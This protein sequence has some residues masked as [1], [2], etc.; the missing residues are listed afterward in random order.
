MEI[1]KT[2]M[3]SMGLLLS[4]SIYA[5]TVLD[6]IVKV[7]P[8]KPPLLFTA[9]VLSETDEIQ[10]EFVGRDG[11]PQCCTKAIIEKEIRSPSHI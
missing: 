5:A 11:K 8:D 4:Q 2:L 10:A 9:G 1:K 3:L 6:G 7:F